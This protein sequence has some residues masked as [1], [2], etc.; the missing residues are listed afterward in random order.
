[1]FDEVHMFL[2]N[3]PDLGEKDLET[4]KS[5]GIQVLDV[6]HENPS[7]DWGDR[8]SKK[9]KLES[10]KVAIILAKDFPEG[11]FFPLISYRPVSLI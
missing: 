10:F 7:E 2:S 3:A 5:L 6:F 4:I 1:V 8:L 9:D 11:F